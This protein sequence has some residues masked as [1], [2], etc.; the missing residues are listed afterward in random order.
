M[1]QLS[2]PLVGLDNASEP[3]R[4]TLANI[5]ARYGFVP[6]LYRIFANAPI[7]ADAYL[8][9]SDAFGRGT[10][11]A[12]ERNVVL[13]AASRENGCHY[14]VAV[15]SAVADMQKDPPH[16]TEALRSGQ[17]IDDA[18]LEALRRLTEAL[19]RGRGHVDGEI[20]SFV[21]AGYQPA[22]VLE[23]LVGITLKTL[24]NY[25]NHLAEPPLDA[26]FAGRA[27]VGPR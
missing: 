21:N 27:W 11:S 3:A 4:T 2:L 20:R 26:A 24:S 5:Q 7:A 25:T 8:A 9:V 1:S 17:P 19:V 23:V 14:C 13:L 15:H 12:T 16:V 18:R 10:L 6:N 22:Q